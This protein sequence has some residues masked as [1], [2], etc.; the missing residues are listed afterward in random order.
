M[1][2]IQ[3]RNPKPH[4]RRRRT[5]WPSAQELA[6]QLTGVKRAEFLAFVESGEAS[7]SFLKRMHFDPEMQRVVREYGITNVNRLIESCPRVRP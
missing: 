5:H 1:H 3:R 7:Q 6:L 2:Y 4:T